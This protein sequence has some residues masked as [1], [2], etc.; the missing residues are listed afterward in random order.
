[1][2]FSNKHCVPCE[3]GIK[4]L[5]ARAVSGYLKDVPGWT[6]DKATVIKRE[7]KFET[8][9]QAVAFVNKVA[10]LTE[11]EGHHPDI[12]IFY[13]IVRLELSTHAIGGLSNNDFILAAKVNNLGAA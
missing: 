6:L 8:F 3:G 2:D 7:F 4:P 9:K 10:D 13:N 11:I 1:M 12:Y 5:D